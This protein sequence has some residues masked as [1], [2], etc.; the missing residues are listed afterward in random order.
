MLEPQQLARRSLEGAVRRVP[1]RP[2]DQDDLTLDSSIHGRCR[3]CRRRRV[4]SQVETID[5]ATLRD[6][7]RASSRILQMQCV[8]DTVLRVVGVEEEVRQPGGKVSLEREFRK[9]PRP[10]ACAVEVEI[11]RDGP[12]LLVEDVKRPVEVID[13]EAA[14]ARLVPQVVDTGELGARVVVRIVRG[15]GK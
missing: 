8:E 15:D 7:G 13:E 5:H 1:I 2:L 11:R 12:R 4:T 6:R 9:Q 10:T 3:N 14:A